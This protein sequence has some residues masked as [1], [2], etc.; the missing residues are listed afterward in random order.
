MLYNI[1]HSFHLSVIIPYIPL[2]FLLKNR[3]NITFCF[4]FHVSCKKWIM[5]FPYH[6]LQFSSVQFSSVQ[7]LSRVRLFAT[8]RTAVRQASLSITNSWSLL[9]LMYFELVMAS[10]HLIHWHPL[11]LPPSILSSIRV[12]SSK[13]VL[14]IR[15][16]KYWNFS[17]SISPNEYSGLIHLGLTGLISLQSKGLS[18]LLQHHSWKGSITLWSAFFIVQLSHPNMTTG[19][20]IALTRWTSGGKAMSLLFN[21]LPR[22]VIAF[23]PRSNVFYFNCCSHHL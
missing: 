10:N 23:L 4:K 9:K 21:M 17:I 8:P 12:F 2:S 15:W 5:S 7:S 22:L 19:K 20:A 11:L 6:E 13:L 16:P 18:S 3:K 14:C 1:F